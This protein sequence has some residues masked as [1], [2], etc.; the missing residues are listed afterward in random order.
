MCLFVYPPFSF[1]VFLYISLS[2]SP[3]SPL[4]L[5]VFPNLPNLLFAPPFHSASF[6]LPFFFSLY[7]YLSVS[8]SIFVYPYF[9]ILHP[10]PP[11]PLLPLTLASSISNFIMSA[12]SFWAV[13]LSAPS[14][15]A[16]SYMYFR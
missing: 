9:P 15:T 6:L 12:T 1:L 5:F 8:L 7:H 11:P 10:P 13:S 14:I 2:L 16:T 4:Y 3:P